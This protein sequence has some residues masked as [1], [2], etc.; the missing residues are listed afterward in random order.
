MIP[1][2]VLLRSTAV[3]DLL[4]AKTKL[5]AAD[6]GRSLA[7]VADAVGMGGTNRVSTRTSQF[8]SDIM[9]KSPFRPIERNLSVAS[10]RGSSDHV[11]VFER[12]VR[13]DR[14]RSNGKSGGQP[15]GQQD[16]V[17]HVSP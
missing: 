3:I 11:A 4:L 1:L 15:D 17:H 7:C 13:T 12:A 8:M 14:R 9:M 5:V 16:L 6:N 10:V 2:S